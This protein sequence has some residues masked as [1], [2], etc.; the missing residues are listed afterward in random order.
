MLLD[1][2]GGLRGRRQVFCLPKTP[3]LKG[4]NLQLDCSN[5][6]VTVQELHGRVQDER[7][8]VRLSG[9]RLPE[10]HIFFRS[11]AAK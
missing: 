7:K 4:T 9:T 2:R 3:A 10:F 6:R 5:P 11:F 8:A 1:I